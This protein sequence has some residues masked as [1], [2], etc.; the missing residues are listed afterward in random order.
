MKQAAQPKVSVI[1]PT[2]N[3]A[4]YLRE[5][6]MSVVAQRGVDVE[7]VVIDDGS[8]DDT[9]TVLASLA[10]VPMLR[11]YRQP[12]AGVAAARNLG[13][14][15]STGDIVCFLD[16]DDVL[17]EDSLCLRVEALQMDRE[18]FGMVFG[19]W[20][21]SP[22]GGDIH[23][24]FEAANV[25]PQLM[26]AIA[27]RHRNLVFLGGEEALTA[28]RNDGSLIFTGTVA[29]TREVV[30][31]TG[32]F[33][34]TR[35][36][37]EDT[38]YWF[39]ALQNTRAVCVLRPVAQYN[40]SRSPSEKY[41]ASVRRSLSALQQP[42]RPNFSFAD[43]LSRRRQIATC[44]ADLVYRK[45][46]MKR[47]FR[48][49]RRECLAGLRVWPVAP[50]LWRYLVASFVP[51]RAAL[52]PQQIR[53]AI[54]RARARRMLKRLPD[55]LEHGGRALRGNGLNLLHDQQRMEPS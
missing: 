35:T 3:C 30:D 34:V 40:T 27:C 4:L 52:F 38:D 13:L 43:A 5:A 22:G 55:C 26:P 41:E 50:V 11:M 29:L 2:Y 12:N 6:V 39:R 54:H 25:I 20:L 46:G 14:A 47:M 10:D 21:A 1:I 42:T 24:Y 15:R 33:D 9:Q 16:A 51:Q 17:T 31:R 8:T 49:G 45:Y 44:H 37:G 23:S 28:C 18:R 48:L 7:I 32:F 53:C 19:D 36:V